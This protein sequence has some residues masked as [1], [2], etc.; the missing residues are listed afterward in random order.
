[1]YLSCMCKRVS[2]H[3]DKLCLLLGACVV[4]VCVC[5]VCVQ[6]GVNVITAAAANWKAMSDVQK[7]AY[8]AKAAAAKK[9]E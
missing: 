3:A 1:M 2:V 6:T 9:D 8:N 5:V 4:C 7:D